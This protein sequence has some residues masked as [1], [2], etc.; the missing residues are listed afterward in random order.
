MRK[1]IIVHIHTDPKFVAKSL[2][3][4]QN[5]E[6]YNKLILLGNQ[7]NNSIKVLDTEVF[8]LPENNKSL[9][10]IIGLC[11]DS[12]MV[13]LYNLK[14]IK[15]KIALNLPKDIL[16]VW[17][18]FGV[19]LYSLLPNKVYSEQTQ[20]FIKSKNIKGIIKKVLLKASPSS[21][22]IFK[23]IKRIDYFMGMYKEEHDYLIKNGFKLPE[24][25]PLS[26][27]E[28]NMSTL[29][30]NK[31]PFIVVGNSKTKFN[32]HLEI[33]NYLKNNSKFYVKMFFSYG[34]ENKYT[35]AVESAVKKNKRI[36]LIKDFLPNEEFQSIYS[37]A[38]ALVIN[39]YRQMAL[40]NIFTA[41]STGTKIYLSKKNSSYEFFLNNGLKVFA[42]EDHFYEDWKNSNLYLSRDDAINNL[43]KLISLHENF[44]LV[45]FQ[46]KIL[47]VLDK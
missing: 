27:G 8:F 12:D 22:P 20:K 5:E 39:S 9:K 33:V 26:F 3:R 30:L 34:G 29:N 41:I 21:L 45:S 11:K 1:K 16:T 37:E 44:D 35:Q 10:Q 32:N 36:E 2:K 7:F 25:I 46:K 43:E 47:A 4:Y 13:V 31:K 6:I 19:E 17:R 14:G 40:G 15:V 23:A 24:F 18:F 28:Y 42:V 38:S